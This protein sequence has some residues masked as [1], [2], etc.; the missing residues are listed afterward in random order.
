MP[1]QSSGSRTNQEIENLIS[2]TQAMRDAV[3]ST[4]NG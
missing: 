3:G 2:V 1:L 4:P